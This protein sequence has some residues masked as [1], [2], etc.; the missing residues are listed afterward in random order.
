[1]KMR[2]A[3]G[4]LALGALTACGA[5]DGNALEAR[6][7]VPGAVASALTAK[8]RGVAFDLSLLPAAKRVTLTDASGI[9]SSFVVNVADPTQVGVSKPVR[10][11]ATQARMLV[12]PISRGSSGSGMTS[13]NV[14]ASGATVTIAAS[15]QLCARPDSL[16]AAVLVNPK[17]N[18]HGVSTTVGK[19]IFAVEYYPLTNV[20]PKMYL[21][22]IV[23]AHGTLEGGR[24]QGNQ[25]L[26]G[27]RPMYG[28][29]YLS[30]SVPVL[31]AHARI[32]TQLYDDTCQAPRLAGG[33]IT[34]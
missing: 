10:E 27:V 22:L 16:L 32:R 6:P 14:R 19:L 30:A 2:K 8:P 17:K 11:S 23:G 18:A 4:L 1:M 29:K 9:G 21:H 31:P 5:G 34:Q 12:Y 33:F 13:V 24:L 28:Y 3:A 7:A 26:E 15:Q 25:Q 20:P